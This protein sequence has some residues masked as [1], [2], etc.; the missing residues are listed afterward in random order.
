MQGSR[1][2]SKIEPN[3]KGGGVHKK[4]KKCAFRKIAK[5]E[6]V[7]DGRTVPK[8]VILSRGHFLCFGGFC[9]HISNC[10]IS[11]LFYIMGLVAFTIKV[12]TSKGR[13]NEKNEKQEGS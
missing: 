8:M 2:S 7:N 11:I 4:I 6:L 9:I 10:F 5:E 13:E 12:L 3:G 1:N